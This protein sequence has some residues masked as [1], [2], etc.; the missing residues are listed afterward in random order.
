MAAALKAAEQGA[1][2]TLVE[3]GTIAPRPHRPFTPRKPVRWRH[4]RNGAGH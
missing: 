4:R 1:Q 2:V 3:R